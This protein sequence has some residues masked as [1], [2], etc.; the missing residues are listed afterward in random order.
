MGFNH[1]RFSDGYVLVY[2]S[3]EKSPIVF[4]LIPRRFESLLGS[5]VDKR[6]NKWVSY[7]GKSLNPWLQEQTYRIGLKPSL[8]GIYPL[9]IVFDTTGDS[10][11]AIP[12]VLGVYTPNTNKPYPVG[13]FTKKHL[14]QDG[15][16]QVLAGFEQYGTPVSSRG[17]KRLEKLVG[18][19][20]ENGEIDENVEN[21]KNSEN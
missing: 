3:K 9:P 16:R 21:T 12:R 2:D 19:T 5:D 8:R 10:R 7:G 14:K 18:E 6:G 13:V 11:L 1:I 4:M 17:M 20:A 15:I